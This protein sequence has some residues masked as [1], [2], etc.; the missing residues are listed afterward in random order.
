MYGARCYLYCVW[1]IVR[2][3]YRPNQSIYIFIQSSENRAIPS[4]ILANG[5]KHVWQAEGHK[6]K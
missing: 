5:E 4:D 1:K 3:A 6:L 2:E